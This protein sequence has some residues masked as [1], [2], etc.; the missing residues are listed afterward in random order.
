MKSGFQKKE[1]K[2]DIPGVFKPISDSTDFIVH[3]NSEAVTPYRL[4]YSF[5]L[6]DAETLHNI[7]LPNLQEEIT[8]LDQIRKTVPI[9]DI[10]VESES[11][12]ICKKVLDG[13]LAVALDGN[14]REFALIKA[15]KS[16]SRSLA[17]PEIEFS[18]EGPKDS[19]VELLGT[20]LNLI[21]KRLPSDRLT[22]IEKKLGNVSK[23]N[24]AILYMEGRADEKDLRY[25]TDRLDS[26]EIDQVIDSSFILQ[27]LEDN[28]MSPF[29]QLS[30]T[31][32]VDRVAGYLGDGKIVILVEGSPYAVVGPASLVEF[33][34]SMEDFYLSWHIGNILRLIR[35][36]A[37]LFSI[38]AT[39][40]YVAVLTYHYELIPKD[41]LSTLVGSRTNIPLPPFLEALFLEVTIELLRE[42]G[43]R[44]P[45]KI[46]QT[47]GIVGGIVIG[48]ASVEAGLT[49]NILLII[50]ALAALASFV[51]PV[52][53][54]GNTIR[55]IRFPFL[56]LSVIW[57]LLG[58]VLMFLFFLAHLLRLT[59]L[60]HPY[61]SPLF[62]PRA[63]AFRKAVF[64]LP[65]RWFEQEKGNGSV[66]QDPAAFSFFKKHA[67]DI[68]EE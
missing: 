45:T 37:V 30:N 60:G 42:A 27:M 10:K 15:V 31:E 54:M 40:V 67:A 62:P 2:A 12:V 34:S 50:V 19:F 53:R 4:Y 6:I 49:S 8:N 63:D 1:Q 48:Q 41:M 47:I 52:Y 59:S 21:R 14:E 26:I 17:A 64:R 13:Y 33:F 51:T 55:L 56:I 58:I 61:M 3:H 16:E 25:V 46:G 38:L 11:D 57:G 29:P 36:F 35:Y 66:S 32:R 24:T 28:S 43:A 44:L 7:V 68:D 65:F 39:P 22:V 18:V 9:E 20:N 23:T 5:S